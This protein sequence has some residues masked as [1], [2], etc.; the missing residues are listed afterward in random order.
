MKLSHPLGNEMFLI[1]L[2]YGRDKQYKC[3]IS[4]Y[5]PLTAAYNSW[6]YTQIRKGLEKVLR[7]KLFHLQQHF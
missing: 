5:I 2:C 6:V 3:Q 7:R 4:Y 1:G